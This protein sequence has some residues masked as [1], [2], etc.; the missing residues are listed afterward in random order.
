MEWVKAV[1]YKLERGEGECAVYAAVGAATNAHQRSSVVDPC[2]AARQR[3]AHTAVTLSFGNA[4][5]D[6]GKT[7]LYELER[8]EGEC[9]V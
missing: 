9:A 7:V 6:W 2:R 8:G 5:M 3:G 1:L 4:Y